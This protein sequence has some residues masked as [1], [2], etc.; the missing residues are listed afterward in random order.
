MGEGE[1]LGLGFCR[2]LFGSEKPRKIL[3]DPC[4]REQ[5][6]AGDLRGRSGVFSPTQP[7]S[8]EEQSDRVQ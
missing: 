7:S 1:K 3:N 4:V 5:G 2:A 8:G 6:C